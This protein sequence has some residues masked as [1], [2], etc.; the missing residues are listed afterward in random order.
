MFGHL[1]PFVQSSQHAA[2]QLQ[3]GQSL[4]QSFEQQDVEA[5]SF[6]QHCFVAASCE[7]DSWAQHSFVQ[8]S[9]EQPSSEQ[10]L[11]ALQSFV[12][13]SVVVQSLQ[14]PFEQ[15]LPSLPVGSAVVAEVE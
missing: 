2:S 11:P 13:Q 7:A 4:Q 12:Q 14:Q 3:F 10:Q 15:Q 8:Q 9:L 5:A 1:H 6:E